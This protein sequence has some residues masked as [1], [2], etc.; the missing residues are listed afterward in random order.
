MDKIK[1]VA[2]S[3]LNTKP[4]LE[5]LKNAAVSQAIDLSVDTP[6]NCADQLIQ[7]KATIG[8]VPVA[9]IP[10]IPNAQIIS[11]YCI[12]CE[13]EVGTV[14]LFSN[15]TIDD[16]QQITLDYQSRTSVQLLQLLVKDF[17]K[18]G[19]VTNDQDTTGGIRFVKGTE[20]YEKNAGPREGVLVIGDRAMDLDANYK[21][22]Y[23]LGKI[24][25]EHT[26][27]PFVFATWVST[28]ELSEAFIEAFNQA[29]EK[30]LSMIPQLINTLDNRPHFSLT[31]Y[32]QQ[33]IS[34]RMD[35]QKEKA[36]DLFLKY[37][38]FELEKEW[39]N[40]SAISESN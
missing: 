23:D 11:D 17:W 12:G 21:Y 10:K 13:G 33:Y 29:L 24:W 36:L 19:T 39:G 32:Y 14:A 40:R 28:R 6:A 16:I 25:Q 2:V 35:A 7:G 1:V 34:F 5:G 15:D 20:G 22:K 8:L 38:G 27:L 37:L 9:M 18:K 26:G 31:K 30:G 4:F 3:Y